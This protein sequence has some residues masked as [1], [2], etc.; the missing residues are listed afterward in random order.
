M[1]RHRSLR[2]NAGANRRPALFSS[3]A[4][5][6]LIGVSLAFAPAA[7]AQDLPTG[8]VVNGGQATISANPTAMTINQTSQNA[9][10]NW[11]SFDIAAGNSVQ[12]VQPNS[13]SVALN[14]VVGG[15]ASAIFGTLSANGQIF[16]INPNG[17]LFG[18]GAEVSVGGLVA[19]TLDMAD[20]DFMAG[21]YSFAGQSRASVINQGSIHADGGYVALLGANISNQ[22]LIQANLGTVALAAGS[23]VTL[24]V[25]GDGLLKLAVD[26]GAIDA[27][28][29]NGGVLR[30]NGG[31]VLLTAQA[32]GRLLKTV[33]NNSGVIEAQTLDGRSGQILLLADMQG[34]TVNVAGVLDASAPNGG[35]GGAI[36]T[37]AAT[38]TIADGVQITTQGALGTTG[39]WLIDPQDFIIGVGGDI[40]GATLS[41]QLVTT[42]VVISTLASAGDG[43]AGN[44]DIFVNDAIAWTASGDPTTLTLNA[45]RDVNINAAITAT[46][47]NLVVCC[48]RDANVNAPITTTN[49]SILL[50]AGQDVNVFFAI[51][52]TDGNI[53]LCAGRDIHIDAAITLTRGSTIPAESLGLPVGLTLIAGS[54]GNGPGME[55]GTL[56]FAPLA[57]PTTV[58]VAP[59]TIN[60]NPVSYSAATDYS[61]HFV[62]TEGASLT[63]RMLLFPNGDMVV[64]GSTQ[65]VLS[66]FNT[67]A[68]SGVP[69]GVS[70][71]AGPGAIANFDSAG[72]GSSVGITYSGYTL[73]G[74]NADQYALAGSC[75]VSTF[76]TTG[77]ISATA[78]PPPPPPPPTPPPSPPPPPSPTTSSP[79]PIFPVFEVVPVTGWAPPVAPPIAVI[80]GG[81]NLPPVELAQAQPIALP[82]PPA[83]PAAIVREEEVRKARVIVAH[84][85]KQARH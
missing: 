76:R 33:V 45:L 67:T 77:T 4:I 64:N 31:Q 6:G 42:N 46:N 13:S 20:A 52:T 34:G 74:A 63:Q 43:T 28:V 39:I 58:T 15:D 29:D 22:G 5:I 18:R 53:A 48:G 19:S 27:L 50:N 9:V 61:T 51:T 69:I 59:V 72:V 75:C 32:A 24:D 23:A 56:I 68:V 44:G 1:K 25:A 37:S 73:G 21:R 84:P 7:Q 79:Y 70:L 65:T 49:G 47:G 80:N 17:V 81:L 71:V 41:A 3:T 60:Y 85:R 14:R 78:A 83:P 62:L 55:K 36:E 54:A 26:R 40:S 10:I 8:G 30:A 16:L 35:N 82:A 12:F 2:A 57:P 38:V 11:Q 66:G